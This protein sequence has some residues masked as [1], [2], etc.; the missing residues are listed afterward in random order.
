M[1]RTRGLGTVYQRGNVWWIQYSFRGTVH[2]ETS[3]S[4][5][6][7]DA[8]RFLRKR[9][10]EMGRGHLVGPDIEKTTFEDLARMLLD[11]Y[12]INRRKSLRTA[13]TSLAALRD[14]FGT[15]LAR[16]ITLDRLNSYVSARLEAGRKPATIGN[17]LA[18]LKRAFH[19]AQR[20]GKAIP[21]PFPVLHVSNVRTG[22]FEEPEVRAVF[23]HLPEALRP[24]V[25]FAHLTGWRIGEILPLRWRQVDFTAGTVRLEPGT[26]KN[27]EGRVFPFAVLP[28][29][30]ALLRRQRERTEALQRATGSIIEHVFH[31]DG[32]PIRDFRGAWETACIKA[33]FFRVVKRGEQTETKAMKLVHDFRRTAVRNLERAG[34]PRSQAMKL[35]GH[36]TEAVYRRYAIVSEADLSEA[37]EKLAAFRQAHQAGGRTVLPFPARTSTVL[38][39]SGG[40][41]G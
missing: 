14:F 7:P 27:D 18:A 15:S 4:T 39:Q 34:V 25:G 30:G 37:V 2:R 40:V 12:M 28:E 23:A 35:T 24:V 1:K 5:K 10:E 8:V 6:R 16:D 33:G 20:A 22:F 32:Q 26:T 36:K 11:D 38:A 13:K 9:L 31:R 29:L 21:P 3:D 41:N 17:E 19:L